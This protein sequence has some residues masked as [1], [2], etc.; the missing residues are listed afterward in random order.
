MD[1]RGAECRLAASTQSGANP[2]KT[3]NSARMQDVADL[4]GV[5]RTTVS[6]AL[7]AHPSIPEKT[8]AAVRR[9]AAKL[10]YRPNP[11][12]AALMSFRRSPRTAPRHTTLAYITATQPPNA[13]RQSKTFRSQFAGAC[14]RAREEGFNVEEFSLYSKGMTPERLNEVLRSRGILGLIVA[15]LVNGETTL[16]LAWD[17]F[18]AVGVAFTL[19]R[20]NVPRLGNDHSQSVRLA[21]QECRRRGYR[22]IG[23]AIRRMQIER[24]EEQWLAGYLVEHT[25]PK[26]VA[27]PPPLIADEWE[28]NIFNAWFR[29]ARP[30]VVLTGGDPESVIAWLRRAGHE[31]PADVGVASLDL[32]ERDGA[33]AGIDQHSEQIGAMVAETLIARLRRNERGALDQPVR[34]HLMGEWVDGASVRKLASADSRNTLR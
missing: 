30:D 3:N 15:P 8:R 21:I 6:L 19:Q 12:V 28:E 22:R 17:E 33:F 7:R 24:V 18:A 2:V 14:E 25:F 16:P 10:G 9:A 23:L 11:L 5:H 20:P 32:H 1:L 27:H 34:T 4:L 31:V 26:T 13:W 29:S